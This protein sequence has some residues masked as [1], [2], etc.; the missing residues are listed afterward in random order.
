MELGFLNKERGSHSY[1]IFRY[2][3]DNKQIIS[4]ERGFGEVSWE[5]LSEFD[6]NWKPLQKSNV[7]TIVHQQAP[8]TINTGFSAIHPAQIK[9]Q[10]LWH[11]GILKEANINKLQQI[12][13][14]SHQVTS[15]DTKLILKSLYYTGFKGLEEF[16]GS[17]ACVY[18]DNKDFYLFRNSIAPLF[19]DDD[20]NISSV[21]FP[22]SRSITA[23]EIYT[24]D[25]QN[26]RYTIKHKSFTSK[27][28]PYYFNKKE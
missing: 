6:S 20:L 4:L 5:T 16:D 12:Y 10:L 28:D 17:F 14:Y 1:S 9:N 22:N 26:K 25:L 8:T 24:V 18:F 2:D 15:W 19:M 3:V 23:N 11:N 27:E 21:E 13:R 7:Y